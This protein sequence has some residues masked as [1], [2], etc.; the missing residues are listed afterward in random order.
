MRQFILLVLALL[1]LSTSA[2]AQYMPTG[3]LVTCNKSAIYDASTNGT[4]QLVALVTGQKIYVCGYVLWAGGTSTVKLAYGT[5]SACGTGTVALTPAYTLATNTG[6]ADNADY[7]RG[8]NT[9]ASQALCITTSAGV[10][11]QATVYYSQFG[12]GP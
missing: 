10:A 2:R 12:S 7:W 11:V 3:T 9:A 8:L 4:T 1:F 5:G 6:L